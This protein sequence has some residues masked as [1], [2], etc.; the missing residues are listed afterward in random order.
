MVKSLRLP[1]NTP[2]LASGASVGTPG[3][4]GRA[5][6]GACL[7]NMLGS[8]PRGFESHSLRHLREDIY[9]SFHFGEVPEWLNGLAC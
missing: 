9:N 6:E 5:A 2:A 1:K 3:R 4:D 7:E 8:H